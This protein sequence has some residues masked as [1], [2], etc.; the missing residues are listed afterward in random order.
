[1]KNAIINAARSAMGKRAL[2]WGLFIFSPFIVHPQQYLEP[3]DVDILINNWDTIDSAIEREGETDEEEA[4]WEKFNE[5][6]NNLMESLYGIRYADET[7]GEDAAVFEDFKRSYREF[8][9][10]GTP[11]GLQKAF[12]SAGWRKGGLQKMFTLVFGAMFVFLG[13]EMEAAGSEERNLS[14]KLLEVVDKADTKIIK[15]NLDRILQ[16]IE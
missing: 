6:G 13:K 5:K 16:T 11:P 2:V 4:M 14:L 9:N 3:K 8:M 1:M 15:D 10:G 7:S 12:E